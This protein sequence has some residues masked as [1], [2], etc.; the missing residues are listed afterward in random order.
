MKRLSNEEKLALISEEPLYGN[1]ICKCE[2]ITEKEILDA[3]HGPL[4]SNT[5]KGIKKRTR[6]GAGLCQV[7]YCE[8]KIMKM[9]AKEFNLSPLEV[10]Y[11]KEETK[12]FVSETKVKL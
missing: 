12:L 9:I 7:G 4:G 5:I 2:K 10:A 1:I 8:E 6:A 11:D 3:M